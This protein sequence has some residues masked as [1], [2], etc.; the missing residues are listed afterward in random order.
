M[1]GAQIRSVG[2]SWW[3]AGAVV[4]T[5]AFFVTVAC[6][7]LNRPGLYMDETNFVHAALGGHFP[8][9]PYVYKRLGGLPILLLSYLGTVK[10]ALFAPIFA[11]WGVSVLTIRLP[12]ILISA[13][14]LVVAY[15]LG[16]EVIGRWSAVFVVLL[17]TCPTF[18][19]MSKIDWGPTA[20][21]MALT[22]WLLLAFFRYLHTAGVGWLWAMFAIALIGLW[23]KQNFAWLLVAVGI[24]GTVVYHRRLW[25]LVR[26]RPR[27]TLVA[28]GAFLVG[29]LLGL[30]L[31]LPNIGGHGTSALQDPLPH[32]S[33][34]WALYQRTAGYSAVISF[35]TGRTVVQP[36]WMDLQWLFALAALAVLALRRG[37]GPLPAR[38]LVPARAAVFFLLVFV[39][40]LVEIAGTKQA[41]G[42]HHVI[43]LVPYAPLVLLCSVVAVSNSGATY[44]LSSVAIA[45]LGVSVMLA[46]QAVATS[47][48]M[49]LLGDPGRLRPVLSTGVYRDSAYLNANAGGADEV[50]SAGWGPDLPLFSLACPNDRQ[51][52]RD[53]LWVRLVGLTPTDAPA[54]VRDL[55]GDRRVL[56]VSVHDVARSGLPPNLYANTRL[57]ETAYR[58]AFP[59]RHPTQVLT[60]SAYDI[61]YFGPSSFRAGRADC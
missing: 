61:T 57:L 12:A 15:Y 30:P 26:R 14:T 54:V 21:A 59:G 4:G 56:L 32:L 60:T 17:G 3:T 48:Y 52:Y 39:V 8:H 29:V 42:P 28:A 43:E 22:I 6:V 53:D 11:I 5:V 55:F 20:V 46:T 40:M 24:A 50:V 44:Q 2:P 35:F 13:S 33:A 18:I 7:W 16:R 41:T 25:E 19:I 37:R 49:A 58:S 31:L 1:S 45:A 23:D 9:Q 51:K 38:A 36:A 47:Q 27:G 34:A 10:A